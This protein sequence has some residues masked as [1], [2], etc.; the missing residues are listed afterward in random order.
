VPQLFERAVEI[1]QGDRA[2][3][4]ERK[5]HLRRRGG[6]L[7]RPPADLDPPLQQLSGEKGDRSRKVLRGKS[8]E[9]V[10]QESSL[11]D[12]TRSFSY[13]IRNGNEVGE[14]RGHAKESRACANV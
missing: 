12:T 13:C 3:P 1:F 7:K 14:P 10:G 6:L 9:K 5:R 4:I 2:L 11:F 8:A